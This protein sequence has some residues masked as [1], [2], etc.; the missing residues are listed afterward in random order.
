MIPIFKLL[1][2]G[3]VSGFSAKDTIQFQL[4]D[5]DVVLDRDVRCA[6]PAGNVWELGS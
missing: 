1:A 3:S 2:L 6:D 5:L 4:A